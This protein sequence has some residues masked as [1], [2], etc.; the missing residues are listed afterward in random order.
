MN[1]TPT[2]DGGLSLAD[3]LEKLLA[4]ATPG[5]WVWQTG[6]SW[7][8]LG[9]ETGRLTDG[10][11]IC[12]FVNHHDQHPDLSVRACDADLIVFLR[13][14]APA[15]L[16]VL[17]P[18]SVESGEVGAL[19]AE[20]REASRKRELL[21]WDKIDKAARLLE[22]LVRDGERMRAALERALAYVEDD[23]T[24]HGRKFGTGNAIRAALKPEGAGK[25]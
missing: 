9:T 6:S 13:N 22:T 16:K 19:I 12:P 15:F 17:R 11:V 5:P 2:T 4:E 25:P 21:S 1:P 18:P 7:T 14:N 24:A 8:R 10:S 20:Y 3:E 23:E